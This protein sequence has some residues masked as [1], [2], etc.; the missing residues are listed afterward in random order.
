MEA[1]IA[2]IVLFW[3]LCYWIQMFFGF[4][5]AYRYT[6]RGGDNGIVLFGWLCVFSFSAIVPGLGIYFWYKTRKEEQETKKKKESDTPTQPQIIYIT[7]AAPQQ[8]ASVGETMASLVAVSVESKD[9]GGAELVCP[10]CGHELPA[11]SKFCEYCG[12]PL[13]EGSSS[14]AEA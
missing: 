11:D 7:Q 12:A 14:D 6:K 10:K 9:P 8:T 13:N 5:T 3:G 2:L 4:G 1:M